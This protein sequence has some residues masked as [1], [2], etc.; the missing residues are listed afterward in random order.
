MLRLFSLS[1]SS[2]FPKAIFCCSDSAS[3]LWSSTSSSNYSSFLWS[4]TKSYMSS[5]ISRPMELPRHRISCRTGSSSNC[6]KPAKSLG[7][8]A[9]G[10]IG[11]QAEFQHMTRTYIQAATVKKTASTVLKWL[12]KVFQSHITGR[13]GLKTFPE[14][15]LSVEF[16]KIC[17]H[18]LVH[19]LEERLH[20]WWQEV[21]LYEIE[22]VWYFFHQ[23]GGWL[24]HCP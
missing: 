8:T 23:I 18:L 5:F 22:L 17:N 1:S 7:A 20:I 10:H 14:Q 19:R 13:I 4:S 6:W 11:L 3:S 15:Y 12:T 16:F 21:G 9:S 2:L 24:E